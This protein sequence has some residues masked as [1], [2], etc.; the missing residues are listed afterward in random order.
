MLAQA[1][2][3]GSGW[4]DLVEVVANGDPAVEIFRDEQVFGW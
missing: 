2:R 3:C 4:L 1:A